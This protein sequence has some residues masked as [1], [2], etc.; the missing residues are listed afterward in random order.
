MIKG[1]KE[2]GA[3]VQKELKKPKFLIVKNLN[4]HPCT[5]GVVIFS[6]IEVSQKRSLAHILHKFRQFDSGTFER[7]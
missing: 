6:R 1:T 4:L 5:E 3:Q 7:G 2:K